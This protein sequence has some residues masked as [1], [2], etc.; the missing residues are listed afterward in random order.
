MLLSQCRH[1]LLIVIARPESQK[2][3]AMEQ[4][5]GTLLQ[6]A[7]QC[8]TKSVQRNVCELEVREGVLVKCERSEDVE[9]C[10]VV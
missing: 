10:R 7:S 4:A 6:L 8:S 2:T 1:D 3:I 5:K 9:A